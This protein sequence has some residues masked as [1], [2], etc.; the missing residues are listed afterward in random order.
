MI[1][2]NDFVMVRVLYLRLLALIYLFAFVSVFVQIHSLWSFS[3]IL[4]QQ[5]SI[6][7]NPLRSLLLFSGI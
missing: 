6:A 5:V 3:G 2:S 4:P 1:L 7:F